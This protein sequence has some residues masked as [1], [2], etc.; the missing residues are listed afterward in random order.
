[1]LAAVLVALSA[2][3]AHAGNMVETVNNN[4]VIETARDGLT[5]NSE[6]LPAQAAAPDYGPSAQLAGGT[7]CTIDPFSGE[8]NEGME[9]PFELWTPTSPG[10]AFDNTA[11]MWSGAY[12]KGTSGWSFNCTIYPH[13]GSGLGGSASGPTEIVFDTPIQ[14]FGGYF[15]TNAISYPIEPSIQFYDDAGDLIADLPMD[16][17]LDCT[18]NWNGWEVEGNS[19][20]RIVI[21]S[22]SYF[23]GPFIQMDDLTSSE[24]PGQGCGGGGDCDLTPV[25]EAL[26]VLEAKADSLEM[27]AD[28]LESKA[29]ALESKTDALESK[30]DS[31]E[32]KSDAIEV[33]LDGVEVTL[34]AMPCEIFNLIVPVIPSAKVPTSHP[35]YVMP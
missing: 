16:V 14:R 25:L 7:V 18:W 12:I 29:D 27:K 28:S 22:G 33:K 26:E 8:Y 2:Y 10:R 19:F 3:A 11:D 13:S 1:L 9:P 35:C 32:T 20:K 15:G 34:D 6:M 4:G 24:L 31:L 30:A 21:T 5:V 23:N 17:P